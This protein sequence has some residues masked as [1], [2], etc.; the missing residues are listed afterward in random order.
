MRIVIDQNI[1]F[2]SEAFGTIGE[3]RPVQTGEFDPK[4][5]RD[6]DILIVR[7]E[8]RVDRGLIGESKV[9]FVGTATIGTDHID[10]KYLEGKSIAYANAPGSNANSVAEYVLAALLVL[11]ERRNLDLPHL[12][13]GIV[14]VGNVGSR[15]AAMATA[16]GMNVLLN[17]PPLARSTGDPKY[18]PLDELMEADIITLHVPLTNEGP[19]ATLHFFDSKRLAAMKKGVVFLNTSR[20]R[21]VDGAALAHAIGSGLIQETVLDVW[22]G[23]PLIDLDLV[24]LVSI[25]TAHIA[26]YSLD[27]KVNAVTTVYEAACRHFGLK[28]SWSAGTSLPAPSAVTIEIPPTEVDLQ[29]ALGLLVP[30]AYDIM[31]DDRQ[32]RG[33]LEGSRDRAGI[34]FRRLRI[35]YRLRRE[36]H[37]TTVSCRSSDH[38]TVDVIKRL[39][40]NVAS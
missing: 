17:D 40:F 11:A 19:D 31:L 33:I 37:A 23:E 27:G 38:G 1:P 30:Q 7:S 18:R 39:G 4:A 10:T 8:T 34:F 24:R 14:G 6:A 29:K 12:T 5:V 32:L 9:R 21:V 20:G 36:F 22:E 28:S 2:G 15:V 35:E 13:I 16:L 25:G 26:G 3:V